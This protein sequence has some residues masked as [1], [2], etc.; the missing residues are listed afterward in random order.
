MIE[1]AMVFPLMAKKDD[2][3]NLS[4]R[5]REVMYAVHRLGEVT[6]ESLQQDMGED[7]SYSAARRYLS[8]LHEKGFLMMRKDGPRYCYRPVSDTQEVGLQLLR[9]AFRNFFRGSSTLGMASFLREEASG[10]TDKELE[11]LE[12][13]LR[14]R[15][16]EPN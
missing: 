3:D 7:V 15:D 8:I 1:K 5:E 12:K 13:M 6:A 4:R 11:K 16:Q 9:N 2:F 14:N 10:K